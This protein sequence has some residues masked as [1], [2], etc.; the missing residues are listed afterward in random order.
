M[1]ASAFDQFEITRLIPISLFGYIDLS[2][3][4][5][6]IFMLIAFGLFYYLYSA[7][8]KN[9]GLIPGRWQSVMEL[10]FENLYG[11]VK[12]NIGKVGGKYLPFIFT[13]FMFIGIMN[14]IGIVPYTFAPTAH[15]I[16]TMGL[17][18]SIFLGV[19]L[20]GFR[21]NGSDY[22]SMFMPAGS[23]MA[24]APFLVIIEIVS[25]FA[26]AVSL[27]V[28]LASNIT[29]GHLLFSI[30]SGFAFDM[31][32]SGSILFISLSIIPLAIILFISFLEIGVALIQA[33]VF[34]LLTT[35]YISDSEHLH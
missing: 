7:N 11:V 5:S 35:I 18:V 34:S 31:I 27:G 19:S 14:L 9:G 26:K 16:V 13:L 23:P 6:T 17:S 1:F 24:L 33:Y 20:M 29:A 3:T 32:T 21:I 22:L 25:H 10:L 30:L 4:N 8:I 28:R 12:D 2:V 15:I